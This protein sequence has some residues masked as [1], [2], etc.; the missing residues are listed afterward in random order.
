MNDAVVR[1]SGGMSNYIHDLRERWLSRFHPV[2]TEYKD[3]LA[4]DAVFRRQLT[5]KYPWLTHRTRYMAGLFAVM[6]HPQCVING[7]NHFLSPEAAPVVKAMAK[8]LKR[9]ADTRRVS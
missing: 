2:I 5:K 6:S 1:R 3:A 7:E 4:I 8:H 9:M